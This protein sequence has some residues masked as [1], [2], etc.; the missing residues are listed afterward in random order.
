MPSSPIK[1]RYTAGGTSIPFFFKLVN[2]VLLNATP[3]LAIFLSTRL[4]KSVS[5]KLTGPEEALNLLPGN[6]QGDHNENQFLVGLTVAAL[7]VFATIL[8]SVIAQASPGLEKISFYELLLLWCSLPRLSWFASLLVIVKKPEIDT[9]AISATLAMEWAYQALAAITML[10]AFGYG[11]EHD[12]Y[13]QWTERLGLHIAAKSVYA[14]ALIWV[15]TGIIAIVLIVHSA[16]ESCLAPTTRPRLLDSKSKKHSARDTVDGLM[17]SFDEQ[18]SHVTRFFRLFNRQWCYFEQLIYRFLTHEGQGMEGER[19]IGRLS[20][21]FNTD[22]GTL[23]SSV[24]P[25]PPLKKLPVR[26]YSISIASFVILWATQWMFWV[27]IMGLT[28]ET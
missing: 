24:V 26:L 22:Y 4:S 16:F 15:A 18:W 7:N 28:S 20:A 9:T 8:T 10:K 17:L 21:A 25:A 3:F 13:L 1:G 2:L 27:G 19:L 23:P 12:F 14:G 6:L 11:I 5:L